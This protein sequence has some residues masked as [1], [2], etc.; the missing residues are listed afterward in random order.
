MRAVASSHS[1]EGSVFGRAILFVGFKYPL[2]WFTLNPY[3]P[4]SIS[5]FSSDEA[6]D[7]A[8]ARSTSA[9]GLV[10]GESACDWK[11]PWNSIGPF[12]QGPPKWQFEKRVIGRNPQPLVF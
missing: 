9:L 7:I 12:R 3:G 10:H 5:I 4:R 8:W 2:F 11:T 6:L 1:R